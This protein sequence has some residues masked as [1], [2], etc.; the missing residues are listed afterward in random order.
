[1]A[2]SSL[3]YPQGEVV[4]INGKIV[5]GKEGKRGGRWSADRRYLA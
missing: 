5:E 4:E 3:I 1:V 2:K